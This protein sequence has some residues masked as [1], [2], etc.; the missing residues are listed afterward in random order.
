M[1]EAQNLYQLPALKEW[2]LK[3]QKKMKKE[4]HCQEQQ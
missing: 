3:D 1:V 2:G 4:H